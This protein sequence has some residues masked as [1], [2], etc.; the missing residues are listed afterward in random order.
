M[1]RRNVMV[2]DLKGTEGLFQ[3]PVAVQTSDGVSVMGQQIYLK[4]DFEYKPTDVNGLKLFTLTFSP[5]VMV[6]PKDTTEIEI[7]A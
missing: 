5:A 1:T 4:V 3:R 7:I 2:F 6:M